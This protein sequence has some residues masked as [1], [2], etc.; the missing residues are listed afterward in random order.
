[1]NKILFLLTILF[2]V[3]CKPENNMPIKVS[4]NENW[5]FKGI[6]TLDWNA[7]T[8]P[9]NI[10]SDLL[11]NKLIK[12]PFIGNN[13]EELQWISDTNWHYKTHFKVDK[14]TLE[15]KYIELNLEG[16]DTY[17][18]VFLNDLLI[19]QTNNAFRLFQ[20]DI[21]PFLKTEND[22]RIE[23]EKTAVFEEQEKTKLDYT[24]PE[25][26]RIFTRKAQF[27]YGWDWGPKLNTSGIWKA[28]SIKAWDD[29][30]I[31]GVDILQN[32]LTDSIANL[33][34]K[35]EERNSLH[36]NL[37]YEVYINNSLTVSLPRSENPEIPL[38]IKSPKKWW[39]HNLGE[40]Y[41]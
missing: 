32:E 19:L 3:G 38:T 17:A 11:D 6:D 2:L 4:L 34:L 20:I 26:N 31:V 16:L 10:H 41:L 37:K 29:Y 25:G 13:E 18:S 12:H 33:T 21:K 9:G 30:K 5:Q 23:F 14:Q 39:P 24:L 1:M 8:V 27:Q 15:K 22:L 36:K 35:I 40:P 28:V 7:A